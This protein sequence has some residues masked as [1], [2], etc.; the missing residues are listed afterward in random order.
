LEAAWTGACFSIHATGRC[1]VEKKEVLKG[2]IP[3][4]RCRT[5]TICIYCDQDVCF[6]ASCTCEEE[7]VNEDLQYPIGNLVFLDW[8]PD[9]RREWIGQFKDAPGLLRKAVNGLNEKQLQNAYR[10]G[11]WTIA[12]V[13]HH[14]AE[15]DAS[16]YTRLKFAL[17]ES[18]PAVA[19]PP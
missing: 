9:L 8:T 11:G 13:V 7:T 19:A 2:W 6:G 1:K 14:L 18:I 15:M 3:W 17:T 12:Q 5:S 16:A 10:A 4:T